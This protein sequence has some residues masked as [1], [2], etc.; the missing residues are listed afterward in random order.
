MEVWFDSGAGRADYVGD[1]YGEADGEGEAS[2][3]DAP[4]AGGAD[5]AHDVAVE[6]AAGGGEFPEGVGEGLNPPYSLILGYDVFVEEELAS[7]PEDSAYLAHDEIEVFDHSEGEGCYHTVE[8]GGGE[9]EALAYGG[10][11]CGVGAAFL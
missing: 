8:G 1:G 10:Y 2:E 11:D 5:G 7:G 3:F 4:E 6:V 9:G